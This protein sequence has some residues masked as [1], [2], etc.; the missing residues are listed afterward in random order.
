MLDVAANKIKTNPNALELKF[1]LLNWLFVVL[2][3]VSVAMIK[4]Q[5]QKVSWG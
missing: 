2:V 3:R 1:P 5:D 4:T